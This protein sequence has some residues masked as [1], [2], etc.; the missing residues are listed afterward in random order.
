[1]A[2]PSSVLL[3]ELIMSIDRLI[4]SAKKAQPNPNQWSAVITL[5]HVSQVDQQ[6]WLPRVNQMVEAFNQEQKPPTF[7]WWEPDPLQTEL[8]FENLSLEQASG[9]AMQARTNLVSVLRN[10]TPEQW[11]APGVHDTFGQVTVGDLIFQALTH[12]EEH[13]SSFV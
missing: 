11:L 9:L 12:D 5:G 10:L 8:E 2:T 1:M 13:R 3:V 4:E 7:S 6:V